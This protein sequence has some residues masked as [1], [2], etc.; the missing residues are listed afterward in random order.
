MS[1]NPVFLDLLL[2]YQNPWSLVSSRIGA[3]G[4]DARL[5]G[6]LVLI[7]EFFKDTGL[8]FSNDASMRD[9][10]CSNKA[11]CN[12]ISTRTLDLLHL[13]TASHPERVEVVQK[14]NHTTLRVQLETGAFIYFNNASEFLPENFY[15]DRFLRI[16]PSW[17]IMAGNFGDIGRALRKS[18]NLDGAIVQFRKVFW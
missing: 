18:G 16:G 17:Q 15:S 4:A 5:L 6:T 11:D 10:M 3:T 7:S 12:I 9:M 2:T 14:P 1:K 8:Q 13:Y